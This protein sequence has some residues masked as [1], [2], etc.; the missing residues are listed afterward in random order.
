VRQSK[1]QGL[2]QIAFYGGALVSALPG[3]VDTAGASTIPLL[4]NVRG[5]GRE[6]SQLF[7]YRPL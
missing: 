1:A 7:K 2:E 6:L 4:F 3:L 5:P